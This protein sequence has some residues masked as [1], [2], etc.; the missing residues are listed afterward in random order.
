MSTPQEMYIEKLEQ[1]IIAT[2]KT[3]EEA[4]GVGIVFYLS[5]TPTVDLEDQMQ[6]IEKL[7]ARG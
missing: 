3:L 1:L 5:S 7:R 4:E 2:D 6:I